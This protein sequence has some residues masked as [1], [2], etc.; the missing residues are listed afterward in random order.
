M[1]P[2]MKP[3]LSLLLFVVLLTGCGPD[4]SNYNFDYDIVVTD[5]PANLRGLN[6]SFDDYNSDLPYPEQ[7]TDIIYS[8]DRAG[9]GRNFDLIPGLLEFSYHKKYDKLNV[10][11]PN[12]DVSR[13]FPDSFFQKINTENNEYGPYSY[14]KGNDILFMYASGEDDQYKIKFVNLTRWGYADQQIGDP[15]TLATINDLGDNLYPTQSS[16]P[17]ELIFCSN[18]EDSVYN[19]FSATY[20]SEI[21]AQSLAA[22]DVAEIEKITDLSSSYDD[23]CPFIKDNLLVFSSNRPG[24]YGGFDLWYSRLVGNTW[25][26]PVNFGEKINSSS[27]EYRPVQFEAI[28]FDLIIFS[29]NRPGGKG[30]FDL[31]IVQTH[32]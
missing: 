3:V 27:D 19:I 9:A 17:R 26:S 15:L 32:D 1:Q 31:Y 6:S 28:D 20:R 24:G 16:N 2:K 29:S 25:S 5:E 8:S 18:R 7:R 4:D 22:G 11:V 14:H 10:T 12:N 13:I 30:G 21:S 23:K